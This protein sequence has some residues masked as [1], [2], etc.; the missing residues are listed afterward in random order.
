MA[1]YLI[2]FTLWQQPTSWCGY[3]RLV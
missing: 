2:S 1:G 3:G